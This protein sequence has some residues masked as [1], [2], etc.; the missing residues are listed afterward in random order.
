MCISP[1]LPHHILFV[2]ISARGHTQG[3]MLCLRDSTSLLAYYMCASCC[4]LSFTTSSPL[5][6]CGVFLSFS[7]SPSFVRS[8]VLSFFLSACL[9]SWLSNA[10]ASF[11]TS[12]VNSWVPLMTLLSAAS[13]WWILCDDT[14]S[15]SAHTLT[16]C[17]LISVSWFIMTGPV[18]G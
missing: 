1:A 6:Q 13:D 5:K 18:I 14:Y 10:V 4:G 3:Y 15:F 9:T 16:F 7:L 8:F 17:H 2:F 12:G 11:W